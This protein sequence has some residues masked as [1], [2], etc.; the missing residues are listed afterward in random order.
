MGIS[1]SLEQGCG[2]P[3][4]LVFCPQKTA[5]ASASWSRFS[6]CF[7]LENPAGLRPSMAGFARLCSKSTTAG[8]EAGFIVAASQQ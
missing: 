3:E 8:L 4:I 1:S 2:N 5:L 7:F 6:T